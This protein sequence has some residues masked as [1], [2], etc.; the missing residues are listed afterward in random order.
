MRRRGLFGQTLLDA[1]FGPEEAPASPRREPARGPSLGEYLASPQSFPEVDRAGAGARMPIAPVSPVVRQP[2]PI[3]PPIQAPLPGDPSVFMRGGPADLA[4]PQPGSLSAMSPERFGAM[5]ERF[6]EY[7]AQA[8]RI[9]NASRF[10]PRLPPSSAG[11]DVPVW[12]RPDDTLARAGAATGVSERFLGDLIGHES[13]GDDDAKAGTSS[14][15][16]SAQFTDG[17][18]LRMMRQ[19]G[20]QYGLPDDLTDSQLLGL[21]SNRAWSGLMA[22][23]YARENQNVMQ[24][25]LGRPITQKEAY[26]GHFLGGDEAADLVAAAE[27]NM[28]D[29]RRFVSRAAV[30]ANPQVFYE[31]GRYEWRNH[32][33]TGR[34]YQH[35]LGGGRA[36]S[37]REV[38]QRQGRNFSNDPLSE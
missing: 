4:P 8:G 14:A 5:R 3:G 10:Q 21:R 18:W 17:T 34:R 26:L 12:F 19:L 36:R 2:G 33:R 13:G 11:A 16:G 38:V 35:Y 23:E 25:A 20:P 32:P 22:G 29:A 24:R 9:A 37:A 15:E 6:G 7:G 28:Q 30:E 31:G 27:G 1:V